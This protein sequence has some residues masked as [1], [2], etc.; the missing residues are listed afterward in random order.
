MAL[1]DTRRNRGRRSANRCGSGFHLSRGKCV[2]DQSV[3][4]QMRMNPGWEDPNIIPW[5]APRRLPKPPLP[6][7]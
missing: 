7:K 2:P 4:R 1:I 5:D 3:S 6:I